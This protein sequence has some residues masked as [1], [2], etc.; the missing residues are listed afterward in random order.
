MGE[1]TYVFPDSSG[2]GGLDPNLLLSMN[3][4]GF[5]GFGGGWWPMVF[6][7]ALFGRD[8]VNANGGNVGFVASQLGNAVA[9]N[10][11][12]ISNLATSLNCTESQI[13][14][15]INNMNGAIG[16]VSN[17][18]NLNAR[19]IVSAITNGDQNIMSKICDCC[20]TM[21]QLVTEQGYQG[22]IA[23][24]N[25]TNQL[26]S[27][28]DA[29]TNAVSAQIAA[30]TTFLS[31][32]FCELEKREMQSKIDALRE[33]NTQLQGVIDNANQ[34][35]AIQGYVAQMVGPLSKQVT[36]IASKMPNTVP[37]P[38]PQ[39]TAVPN[40]VLYGGYGLPFAGGQGNV[41]S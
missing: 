31:D 30:Q 6:L 29:N 41:F 9:G 34:T 14:A 23:T 11:N 24:L 32:K 22:Q 28:I 2:N 20:C 37:V 7:W 12:A 10:A 4:G 35:A 39:L 17:I 16:Q 33:K 8:G 25:Q 3:G 5:G 19:D 21:R 15:A 18:M 27:K 1:K 38:Y 13:L 40:H 26:G 36:E